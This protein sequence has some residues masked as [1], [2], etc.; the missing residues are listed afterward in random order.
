MN[1]K[2]VTKDSPVPIPLAS[3][4]QQLKMVAKCNYL[5]FQFSKLSPIQAKSKLSIIHFAEF[6]ILLS[7]T[8]LFLYFGIFS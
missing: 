2:S 6:W 8:Y 4:L 1:L 5:Q 7:L 3:V